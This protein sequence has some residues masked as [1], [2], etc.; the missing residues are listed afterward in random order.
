L[1]IIQDSVA[2]WEAESVKMGAIYQASHVTLAAI[3][4]GD[5]NTAI[6]KERS[7]ADSR[8]TKI[9]YTDGHGKDKEVR[10]RKMLDQH[11]ERGVGNGKGKVL[12][13]GPLAERAWALQEHVLAARVLLFTQSEVLFECR[14]GWRCECSPGDK[15]AGM[16]GTT[17]GMI[18]KAL[19]ALDCSGSKTC[20]RKVG[21]TERTK[22]T[23][24]G[25]GKLWSTWHTLV[26]SYS[27]RALTHPRDKLPALSGL[28]SQ[29]VTATSSPYLAGLWLDNLAHDLLWSSHPSLAPPHLAHRLDS[30]RAPSFSWASVDTQVLYYEPDKSE[31]E[32]LKSNI[33]VV[34]WCIDVKGENPLGEVTGGHILLKGQVVEGI[35][36]ANKDGETRYSVLIKGSSSLSMAPDSLIV[37]DDIECSNDSKGPGEVTS[38]VRRAR[39]GE[40][41]ADLRAKVLC[42]NIAGFGREWVSGLVLGLSASLPGAYERVGVFESG[43]EVFAG[44]QRREVRLV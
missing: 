43:S 36:V 4:C 14:T 6:F 3:E 38:T 33:E 12:P 35:L 40:K 5:S 11:P 32:E 34:D 30:C 27:T 17:P 16:A 25:Y 21:K 26:A 13:K 42:M 1:C 44:T 41:R 23:C 37:E 10:V 19:A 29:I 31:G 28:A 15:K 22:S 20:S 2:D 7:R 39:P 24:T 18:P 8:E 9:S